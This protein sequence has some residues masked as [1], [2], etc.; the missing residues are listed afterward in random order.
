[1]T[2]TTIQVEAGWRA[3]AILRSPQRSLFEE[4]PSSAAAG[5]E[6]ERIVRVFSSNRA[7]FYGRLLAGEVHCT[8]KLVADFVAG[9]D[10]R[11]R[12]KSLLDPACGHGHLLATVAAAAESPILRGVE[13][14]DHIA[15]IA[16]QTWGEAV[17]IIN[18]V[19]WSGFPGQP[20]SLTSEA[21]HRP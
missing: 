3:L 19:R 18:G 15:N 13:I 21:G 14:S 1:M 10:M 7:A 12:P 11:H 4:E 6:A 16:S 20:P 2:I 5:D 9:L 17:E 8:P